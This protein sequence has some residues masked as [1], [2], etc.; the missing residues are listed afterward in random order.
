MAPGWAEPSGDAVGLGCE[1][2][3]GSSGTLFQS[4]TWTIL[5]AYRGLFH[6]CLQVY[7]NPEHL[8][9]TSV[10]FNCLRRGLPW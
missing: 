5:N 8:Q 7:S 3:A 6:H 1:S 2:L 10:P 9:D 4:E